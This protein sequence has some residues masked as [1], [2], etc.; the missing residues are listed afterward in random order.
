MI[1]LP[2][3]PLACIPIAAAV[4]VMA[5]AGPAAGEQLRT[6]ACGTGIPGTGEWRPPFTQAYTVSRRGFGREFHPI[7]LRW[8]HHSGQD[9]VS[10]PGPGPVVAI[11]PGRVAFAGVSRGGYGN[12]VDVA[13]AGGVT[14]RY[15]HLARI[16]VRQGQPVRAG[17]R[18][19]FEGSTGTSTGNHLHLE[20]LVRGVAT[21]PVPWMLSHGA[22]L[23]GKAVTAGTTVTSAAAAGGRGA[24]NGAATG[25]AGDSVDTVMEGGIG[26]GLPAPGSPRQASLRNQP[27]P[28]PAKV[29]ALYQA[30]AAR[31]A[32]PWT[33]LAGI[34]MEETG[35][36][37]TTATSSAGA[38]GLMQFMPATFAAVGVDGDGDGLVDIRND[39]DSITSAANYL[40]RSGVTDGP[41]GVTKALYAYNHA[42]WYVNDVLHYA[43]AYGGGIVL[44]DPTG[45]D[46]PV[47]GNGGGGGDASLP[48]LT[49]DRV[50]QLLQWAGSQA[51]D[52]YVMGANGPD[53]WDCS[54]LVQTAF[55]RIG[56]SMPRT[57]GAQRAWLA[58]GNG[59]RIRPGTERP[60][61]VIFWDSYL[62][63]SR[64][65]HVMLVWDPATRTTIEARSRSLGVRH[66]SY[67]GG[68]SHHIFEIWRV[69]NMADHPTVT[70]GLR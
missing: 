49:S 38:Q 69:G 20:I 66:F 24:G 31:Y 36:G 21:D 8:E 53:A 4:L 19:G 47:D 43:H 22:P 65:G 37:R 29:K 45:C 14:S 7:H 3:V 60:G 58:K 50:R 40:V 5:V 41:D 68:P 44:G 55:A 2:L 70:K 59:F 11:G 10:Q 13:H 16:D 56:I 39:A 26:F 17:E 51:G 33:L 9:L 63:P 25:R 57:A 64:I 42:S 28:I 67:A 30:A 23:N 15:A 46:G 27:L 54:S 52:A 48:P 18:L 35:H 12:Y 61:D 62:G 1:L 6:V 34:G 32:I